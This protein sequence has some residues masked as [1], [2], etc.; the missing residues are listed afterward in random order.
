MLCGGLGA[1]Q[2]L[3]RYRAL[4]SAVIRLIPI[5][6][7]SRSRE[8]STNGSIEFGSAAIRISRPWSDVENTEFGSLLTENTKLGSLPAST[9][10]IVYSTNFLS[11]CAC[12]SLSTAVGKPRRGGR[13]CLKTTEPVMLVY[14][15]VAPGSSSPL[16]PR[17][18]AGTQNPKWFADRVSV[19]TVRRW[20]VCLRSF[21]ILSASVAFR[22]NS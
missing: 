18:V 9:S 13:S 12:H 8:E 2:Q 4:S 10:A 20:P 19:R 16:L 14:A 5:A 21:Q 17:R 15:A 1:T 7:A 6:R 11:I 22:W 3:R